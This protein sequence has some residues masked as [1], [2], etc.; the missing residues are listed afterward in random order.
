LGTA[1]HGDSIIQ[2]HMGTALLEDSIAWGQHHS[3]SLE[4]SF[5]W[6][7]HHSLSHG[8][9][10]AWGQLCL[11]TAL[12]GD[13]FTWGPHGDN[14]IQLHKRQLS[15]LCAED[16][17]LV[18]VKALHQTSIVPV[19]NGVVGAV[20]DLHFYGVAPIIDQEDDWVQPVPDHG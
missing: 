19:L 13:S 2:C 3:V 9:S 5:T 4:A 16:I 20:M 10:F 1:S 11:G 14:I 8:D 7:Q 15:H 12:H 17:A 6:G 18:V